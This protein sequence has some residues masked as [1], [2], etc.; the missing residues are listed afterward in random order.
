MMQ[1]EQP[2]QMEIQIPQVEIIPIPQIEVEQ[3]T[4]VKTILLFVE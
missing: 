1:Q 3:I 2:V 4:V